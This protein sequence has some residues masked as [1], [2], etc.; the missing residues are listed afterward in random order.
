MSKTKQTSAVGTKRIAGGI[1]YNDVLVAMPAYNEGPVIAAV[2][3][4]ILS[5]GFPHVLV[6]NDCSKDKTATIAAQAGAI[7][8][9]HPVNRGAGAATGTAIE[10]ARRNGYQYLCLIDA[11]GQHRPDEIPGLL[12]AGK[13]YDMV[14]GSRIVGV[15]NMPIQRRI[16]NRVGSLLTAL[17]FGVYI[18]DSQS[19]F[20]LLNR[21]AIESIK[22]T[23]DRF[24]FA[25][26]MLGEIRRNKLSVG[27][28]PITVIYTEHSQGKTTHSAGKGQ[29]ILNGFW[30]IV[31]FL[32]KH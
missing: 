2:V 13:K 18:N 26:E 31:R 6:V 15:K 10:Y 27:E 11:D 12:A 8:V 17:F 25:S 24:E 1:S 23:Y 29:N 22:I 7:V 19:G 5:F 28:V 4:D 9:S 32:L 3:K 14:V 30:M 16:A 21:R 20:R